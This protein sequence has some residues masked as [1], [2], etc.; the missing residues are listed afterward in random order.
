MNYSEAERNWR[1]PRYNFG[2]PSETAQMINNDTVRQALSSFLTQAL[3]NTQQKPHAGSSDLVINQQ[4]CGSIFP[5]VALILREHF[6]TLFVGNSLVVP[7]DLSRDLIDQ[8]LN[9]LAQCLLHEG[10]LPKWRNELLDVW[11]GDQSIGA[12]ERGAVRALGLVTRAVHLNAWSESGDLWVARRALDKATDPGLWDTLVGGLVGLGEG[13]DLALIRETAEEAGLDEMALADRTPLRVI[14]RMQR[15][16][17]EG[18]QSEDVITCECVLPLDVVPE[19]QD[20]EVMTI[21]A[22]PPNEV[23]Q[24]LLDNAFTVEAG[25]VIA[26]ELLDHLDRLDHLNH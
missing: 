4:K 23:A 20:G 22:L 24:M 10:C 6:P 25:I 11:M 2:N 8:Q 21:V 7:P 14:T 15:Q 1:K 26:Q 12:I 18:F 19:N 5:P 17:P 3:R 9:A 16:L 13:D